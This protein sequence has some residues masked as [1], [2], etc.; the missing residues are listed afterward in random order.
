MP[1]TRHLSRR[2]GNNETGTWYA[3]KSVPRNLQLVVGKRHLLK[4]LNTTDLIVARSRR[5]QA[6]AEFEVILNQARQQT[7]ADLVMD[8]ALAWRKT[9]QR[10]DAGD[11][12]RFWV[13]PSPSPGT[14]MRALALGLASDDI[15]RTADEIAASHSPSLARTFYG[16]ATGTATPVLQHVNSWLRE[17]GTKGPFDERTTKQYRMALDR[18]S[19][20]CR[21]CGVPATIET[22]KKPVAGRYVTDHFV[23]RGINPLT[24]NRHICALSSYW[25]WLIKRTGIELN[26]WQGQTISKAPARN[27]EKAK[28]PFTDHEMNVL[29]TGGAKQELADAIRVAA[30]SGMRM[31]EIYRLTVADTASRL[32]NIR[33]SKTTA[34]VRKVPIHSDLA[35]IVAR[36]TEGKAPTAYLFHKAPDSH[37]RSANLSHKFTHYRLSVGVNEQE[38]GRRQSRVDFHS[39]RRWFVTKARNAGIDR[40]VV[41]AVVGHETGNLTDD[42]YSGGPSLQQRKACVEAVRLPAKS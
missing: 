39:L 20:W 25:R 13:H 33:L 23:A 14:D 7:G 4:S 36:R 1:E 19:D 29:L 41:A 6:L 10:I 24:T 22:I 5:H 3:I 35:A 16:V 28:R 9:V 18:F 26:P 12:S 38:D 40:A 21:I 37:V 15:E 31:E 17:G 2:H 34:G 27:G 11:L 30:L 42:V 32:F 8:T